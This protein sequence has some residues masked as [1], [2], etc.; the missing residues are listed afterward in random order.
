MCLKLKSFV[1]EHYGVLEL[2]NL[3]SFTMASLI[4][5]KINLDLFLI[6]SQMLAV[7]QAESATASMY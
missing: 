7:A 6:V 3:I 5:Y 2:N 1:T 4:I